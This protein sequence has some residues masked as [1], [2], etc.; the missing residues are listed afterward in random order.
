MRKSPTNGGRGRIEKHKGRGSA[1][2]TRKEG[3]EKAD[4]VGGFIHG[5][6]GPILIRYEGKRLRELPLQKK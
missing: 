4:G 6:R 2:E 5:Q 1:A 3:R